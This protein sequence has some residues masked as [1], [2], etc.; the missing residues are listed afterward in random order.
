MAV[1]IRSAKACGSR[2]LMRSRTNAGLR[3]SGSQNPAEVWE[4]VY[5]SSASELLRNSAGSRLLFGGFLAQLLISSLIFLRSVLWAVFLKTFNESAAFIKFLVMIES[6]RLP[7][8]LGGFAFRQFIGTNK[9]YF[10]LIE[11][12]RALERFASHRYGSA[13]LLCSEVPGASLNGGPS[14]PW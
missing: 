10:R 2:R 14:S 12:G 13:A 7:M 11:R 3:T 6:C 9:S 5:K 8:D 1:K 4:E